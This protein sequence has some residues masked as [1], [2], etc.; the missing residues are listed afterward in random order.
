MGKAPRGPVPV[1]IMGLGFIG[2]Q[3]ARAALLSPEVK[4]IGA[5]DSQPQLAGSRLG[6]LVQ[7]AS[8]SVRITAD[9][10]EAVGR[11]RGAVVL[12]ATG[13]RLPDV[14]EQILEAVKAGC[15]VVSSCEELA[16]PWL[17]HDEWAQKLER[18]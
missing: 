4:L 8:T 14:A 10:E 16:F 9:L 12:H 3:I 17:K 11:T 15:H 13:S 7:D 1:V 18:A 2:R 5:V 6:E